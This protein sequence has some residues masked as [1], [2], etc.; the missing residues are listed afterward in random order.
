MKQALVGVQLKENLVQIAY[1]I[2]KPDLDKIAAALEQQMERIGKTVDF[3][4]K[5]ILDENERIDMTKKRREYEASLI[6]EKE[7]RTCCEAIPLEY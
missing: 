3:K 6:K 4:T 5:N 7:W 1:D 2:L